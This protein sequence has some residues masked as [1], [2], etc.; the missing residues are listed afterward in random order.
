ML[1]LVVDR[2]QQ[3]TE[4]LTEHG[5]AAAGLVGPA[6]ACVRRLLERASQ[7]GVQPLSVAINHDRLPSADA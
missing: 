1:G 2:A 5:V 3:R 4:S 6:I 7:Q